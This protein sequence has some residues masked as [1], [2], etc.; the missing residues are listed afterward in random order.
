[1]MSSFSLSLQADRLIADFSL[2]TIASRR[3]SRHGPVRLCPPG[4]S[5]GAVRP[6]SESAQQFTRF[7]LFLWMVSERRGTW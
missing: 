4:P 5:L 7:F 2:V 1:M 6:A 3:R